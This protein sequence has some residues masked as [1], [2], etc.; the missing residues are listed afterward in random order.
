LRV[1]MMT[2]ISGTPSRSKS[3]AWRQEAMFTV[4]THRRTAH[5]RRN[6]SGRR[7]L[8]KSLECLQQSALRDVPNRETFLASECLQI[9]SC[10]SALNLLMLCP[11]WPSN[12]VRLA[13][14]RMLT[15]LEL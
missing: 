3:A 8:L 6:A 11:G 12:P 7:P 4:A 2:E 10:L 1:G 5:Y 9:M 14:C 13:R 15:P